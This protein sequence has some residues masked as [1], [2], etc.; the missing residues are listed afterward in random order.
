MGITSEKHLKPLQELD[1]ENDA[2]NP[3]KLQ[4]SGESRRL[5]GEGRLG[6]L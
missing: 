1:Q 6:I 4:S 3:G 2:E 5:A